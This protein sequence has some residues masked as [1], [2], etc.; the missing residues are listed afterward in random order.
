MY[1]VCTDT[2]ANKALHPTPSRVARAPQPTR[3]SAKRSADTIVTIKPIPE[4]GD[5]NA[6]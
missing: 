6:E 3:V 5:A 2:L 1:P 4:M